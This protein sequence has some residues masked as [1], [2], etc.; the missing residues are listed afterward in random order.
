MLSPPIVHIVAEN[1]NSTVL[2]F[3]GATSNLALESWAR[4]IDIGERNAL[5]FMLYLEEGVADQA[6]CGNAGQTRFGGR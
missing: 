4:T 2:L 3:S 5:S 6:Y 1:S